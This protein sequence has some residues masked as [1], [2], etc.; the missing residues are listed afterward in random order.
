MLRSRSS[1]TEGIQM[2]LVYSVHTKKHPSQMFFFLILAMSNEFGVNRICIQIMA[3]RSVEVELIEWYFSFAT[4]SLELMCSDSSRSSLI[5]RG[6]VLIEIIRSLF[7]NINFQWLVGWM[8]A[9][10]IRIWCRLKW[11]GE[12][13]IKIF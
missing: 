8:S 3:G 10:P 2:R 5:T 1:G 12:I 4:F 6:L 11:L 7:F 9:F 13:R